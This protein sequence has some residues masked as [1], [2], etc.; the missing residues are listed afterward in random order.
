MIIKDLNSNLDEMF[1][2]KDLP[3]F[4]ETTLFPFRY[5]IVI[6]GLFSVIPVNFGT[7]VTEKTLNDY[8]RLER[9]YKL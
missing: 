6:D 5:Q 8:E 9:I 3:M 4:V 1:S 7:N 2:Y